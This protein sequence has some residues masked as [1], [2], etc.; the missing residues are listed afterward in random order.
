MTDAARLRFTP[1]T[2]VDRRF[3]M[4]MCLRVVALLLS[5]SL[6]GTAIARDRADAPAPS[7]TGAQE[8]EV[9]RVLVDPQSQQPAIVLQS[10]RDK[11]QFAMAIDAAQIVAIAVPLQGLTPP[12][13]LTHDLFLTMFG[14]LKVTLTK[15]IVTDFRD[16]IYYASVFLQ[17]GSGEI[18]L[19]SRPSDAIALAVRA[20]VPVLVEDKVFEKGGAP[21][22][23]PRRPHI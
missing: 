16:D 4:R 20:K 5:L 2:F 11:R 7:V 14:R 17:T 22:V 23:A 13:P 6:A 21:V 12:R 15:V 18:V 19:D 8:V 9:V 1:R 3:R 10:K